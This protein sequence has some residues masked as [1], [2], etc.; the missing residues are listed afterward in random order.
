MSFPSFTD[1]YSGPE[2]MD[3]LQ[4]NSETLHRTLDDFRIINKLFSRSQS[5]L[6][7]YIFKDISR[8]S[9]DSITLLDIGAGGGDIDR[10]FIQ[11]A[12]SEG[13][14]ATVL[15][16]DHDQRCIDYAVKKCACFHEISFIKMDVFD[17]EKIDMEPDY[18]IA[19]HF[20]HH[21]DNSKIPQL[22]YKVKKKAKRGFVIN[23]L[24]RSKISYILFYLLFPFFGNRSFIWKDGLMSIRKGFTCNEL[25]GLIKIAGFTTEVKVFTLIPGRIVMTNL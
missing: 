11:R 12:R 10:W 13:I 7:K 25:H 8:E 20:L 1:R 4:A 5:G 16:I 23:D 18:V 14:S 2:L 15:G 22:L 6:F 19:N 9:C 3:D 21:L 17:L 24:L